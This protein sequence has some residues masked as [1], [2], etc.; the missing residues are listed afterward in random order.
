MLAT[1]LGSALSSSHVGQVVSID[2]PYR[3]LEG[4][5]FGDRVGI[6]HAESEHGPWSKAPAHDERYRMVLYKA[7]DSLDADLDSDIKTLPRKARRDLTKILGSR[8]H[9]RTS[10]NY[11]QLGTIWEGDPREIPEAKRPRVEQ[12]DREDPPAS[13][14]EDLPLLEERVAED[15]N[16]D[17]IEEEEDAQEIDENFRPTSQQIRDLKIAHDNCGHPTNRDFAR[18]IKLGNGK[19]EIAR[20]VAKHFSCDDCK[21]H[22]PPKAKRP[23]AIPRSYRFNHVVGIDLV[24]VPDAEGTSSFGSTPYVGE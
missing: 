2:T 20:W 5:I 15:P 4:P 7:P 8:Q 12:A 23:S 6:Y 22:R 14:L 10:A 1:T 17:P 21:A 3:D 11:P 13:S 9:D 16:A 19:P 18:M 24:E